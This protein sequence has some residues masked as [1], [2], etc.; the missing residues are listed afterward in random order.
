[1]EIWLQTEIGAIFGLIK[2]L[3]DICKECLFNNIMDIK[4]LWHIHL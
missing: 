3:L 2:D 4:N 1:L